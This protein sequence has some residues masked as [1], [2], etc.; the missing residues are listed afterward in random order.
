[1]GYIYKITNKIDNKIYIGQTIRDVFLRW[2]EHKKQNSNC[3]YLK[4]AFEKYGLK[5]FEFKLICISFDNEL[6]KLENHYIKKY[7]SLVPNGYNLRHGGNNGKV[8]EETK[9][10]FLKV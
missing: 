5:N 3:R 9:K 1:M 4:A 10:K 6:D 7:N 8:N 2:R